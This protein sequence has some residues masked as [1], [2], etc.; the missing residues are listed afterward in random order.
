MRT[1][2]VLAQEGT[3]GF[4][5]MT[6]G[7]VFGLAN[8]A[9]AQTA[10]GEAGYQI[11]VCC[12]GRTVSTVEEWGA[13]QLRTRHGLDD[14]AGAD[15]V[16]VPGRR[17]FLQPPDAAV[18]DALRA[19][20]VGGS[21]IAAICVG[22]FT[23]AAAGLLDGARATTH[24]QWTDELARRHP[25]VEVD[26]S[27][28]FVDNGNTLT[29]AGVGAGLDLCLHL[30]RSDHGAELAAATARRLVM[31]AWRAGGQAQF[32]E[33]RDVTSAGHPLQETI[34]WMARNAATTLDLATIADH[35]AMSVRSLSRHFRE[36]VGT[37]PLELLTRMRVDRAR[38]LLESTDLPVDRVAEQAGFGSEA[39]LRHHFRRTVG[40]PPQKYRSSYHPRPPDTLA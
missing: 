20:A 3:I 5:V 34:D 32:I 9:A 6:P 31:P 1:V 26:P 39:S 33:H 27:V 4:E 30:I 23:V 7:Q 38:R 13:T 2:A 19:A 21:R 35:A 28:L 14:I 22:A 24:W 29:S 8:Q 12:P 36:Y 18:L 11:R 15:V 10:L 37:T 16:V 17:D 40:V 25:A